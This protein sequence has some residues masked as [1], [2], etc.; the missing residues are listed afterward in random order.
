MTSGRMFLVKVSFLQNAIFCF[1]CANTKT[2]QTLPYYFLAGLY[3]QKFEISRAIINRQTETEQ[4]QDGKQKTP[5]K[6]ALKDR[7]IRSD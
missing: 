3:S 6:L 1:A 2:N 5:V 4:I 7:R